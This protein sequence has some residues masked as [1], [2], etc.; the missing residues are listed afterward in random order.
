M[1]LSS[2]ITAC[3]P[4]LSLLG[5]ACDDAQAPV[6]QPD[7]PQ[8]ELSLGDVADYKNDGNWGAATTCK[9]IP[10]LIPLKDPYIVVSLDG[11]TLH[12]VD[13]QGTYDK[14][15]PIGPGALQNG[16]SLTP[17]S[18]T[19]ADQLF[20]TR[21]DLPAAKDGPTANQAVWSYNY[22][23]RMW[24]TEEAGGKVPV[25]AGLPF[26]RLDGPSS[27]GYGIHGPIDKYT[28]ANGGS[29]RRGFV[30]HGCMRME[31]ADVVEVWALIQG[32]KTPVR[33]QQA[34][35]R[36][37]SGVAVDLANKWIGA[38][39]KAD[40]DCNYTGGFCHQNA[41]SGRGF[42]SARCTSTCADIASDTA[43]TFC[44]A[45]PSDTTKGMCVKKSV[46]SDG[47]CRRYDQLVTKASVARFGQSAKKADVCLPGTE[48]WMG[49][50]CLADNECTGGVCMPVDDGAGGLCTQACDKTC[51][52]KANFAG[53]F[54]VKATSESELTNGMC[55][56]TCTTNDDCAIGTTCDPEPR[57]KQPSVVKNVC[58]PY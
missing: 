38:E 41:Y 8:E 20:Y 10:N 9:A 23:C 55:L 33:I 6:D 51:P 53:T 58:L 32:H 15:F 31:A 40:A 34:V 45:D 47:V 46:T 44:V 12:L 56:S 27:S 43:T 7:G 17:V 50:R 54:C 22:S 19:R 2:F 25:F 16:K 24:W 29:L 30:S 14:T 52:D 11:L 4:V 18:T 39:C 5:A 21:T 3:L 26:I 35:E 42:C 36:R 57:N 48:G 13:R 49:D 1:R 37:A 28:Q